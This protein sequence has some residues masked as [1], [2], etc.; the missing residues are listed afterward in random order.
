MDA[1]TAIPKSEQFAT[2]AD[3]LPDPSGHAVDHRVGRHIA[4]D[5]RTCT[6]QGILAHLDAR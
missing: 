6:N 2:F 1:P 5:G 3:V 4:G